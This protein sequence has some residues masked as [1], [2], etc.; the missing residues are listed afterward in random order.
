MAKG[1][2]D[3]AGWVTKNDIRCSDGVVIKQDAFKESH[4]SKVPLVWLHNASDIM[5]ILG[6]VEL[7]NVNGGVYGYGYLNDSETARHAK[8]LIQAGTIQAMSIGAKN[9]KRSGN[10]VVH[11]RIYEVSL[12]PMGANPGALIETV[13]EHSDDSGEVATIFPGYLLHSYDDIIR[14]EEEESMAKTPAGLEELFSPEQLQALQ[15][16]LAGANTEEGTEE[17]MAH[18]DDTLEH[19]EKNEEDGTLKQNIFDKESSR[20][21]SRFTHADQVAM[22]D[23]MRAEKPSSYKEFMSTYLGDV[24]FHDDDPTPDD[25]GGDDNG[26]VIAG[27][28]PD[29]AVPGED[30]GIENLGYLF[31]EARN[32]HNQPVIY[33]DTNTAY[34]AILSAVTKS[35]F[36]KIKTIVADFTEEE[37]R[38]KGYIT[39]TQKLEQVFPLIK[40]ETGPQTIYKKQRLDRDDII[41]ITDFDVVRFIQ[42]EMRFMLEEEI[43]RALLV[44]DGR[45]ITSPDKIN[46]DRIIPVLTDDDF[47]TLKRKFAGPEKFVE[48]VIKNVID[49]KGSG[50]PTL[51]IDPTL[52]ADVKLLKG[53]DGR[54]LNGHIPTNTELA[55]QMEVA[56]IVPTTFMSGNGALLVNLRDYRLGATR[57]GE[58]TNFSDFDIDFNQ[59]KYLIETRLSGALVL[60]HAAIHFKDNGEEEVDPGIER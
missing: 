26:V 20:K 59:Y 16:L 24:L 55:A 39:G 54:W 56:R 58:I 60:P 51:Y 12:V 14:Q 15:T 25:G 40:R 45:D 17:E 7:E 37:A 3:F 36:S 57:G 5:N 33:R 4:G 52:L 32:V 2:Y 49:Y 46:E 10:D 27:R 19:N 29:N 34:Q 53:T 43:A 35:P 9:V 41:D 28:G 11:G 38:A 22:F 42:K 30:Y 23:K 44:G 47:Y 1:K 18:K 8:S 48:S 6:H 13:M 31:P 21:G 50:A